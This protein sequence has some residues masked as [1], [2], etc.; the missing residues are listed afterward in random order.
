ML[1]VMSY[2]AQI[3][4][5]IVFGA[6]LG[7]FIFQRNLDIGVGVDDTDGKGLQCH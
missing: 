7:H 3:I 5:A 6:F 2:N 4:S 1:L